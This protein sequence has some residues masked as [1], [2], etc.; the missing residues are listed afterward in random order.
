MKFISVTT[1]VFL[2][3]S[4]T[5]QLNVMPPM[6]SGP[7][8]IARGIFSA[9]YTPKARAIVTSNTFAFFRLSASGCE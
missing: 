1:R 2:S 4:K 8:L 9:I 7:S 5:A 3:S 6:V